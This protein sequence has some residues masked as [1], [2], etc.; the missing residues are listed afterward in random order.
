MQETKAIE[1][2]A[3]ELKYNICLQSAGKWKY[4]V[5]ENGNTWWDSSDRAHY[6]AVLRITRIM[7]TD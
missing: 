7:S 3:A 4:K 1:T 5:S 6:G 2:N